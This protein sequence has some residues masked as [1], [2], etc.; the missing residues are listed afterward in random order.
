M[1][2]IRPVHGEQ[3]AYTLRP[4]D[5][6]TH[7]DGWTVSGYIKVDYLEWVNEFSAKHPTFGCVRG[8]FEEDVYADSLD[9]YLDF[10]KHHPPYEWDY[11]DI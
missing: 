11:Q 4:E 2:V 9:G 7:S 1:I 3:M 6:G 10:I 8:N 5:I